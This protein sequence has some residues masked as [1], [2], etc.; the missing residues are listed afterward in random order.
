MDLRTLTATDVITV[1]ETLAR[2]F[3]LTADPISPPGVRSNHLLESAVAR[4]DVSFGN[5][6]KYPDPVANAATLAYGICCNHPFHNGNKRTALVSML[7]H[8]DRNK[9]ALYQSNQD[10][11]Y[12]LMISVADHSVGLT[13]LSERSRKKFAR[14][15]PDNEVLAIVN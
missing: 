12:E 8:L 14:R 5:A 10:E 4:Q 15:D 7:V 11:L 1:H 13:A 9:L 2:D 6:L 3:A